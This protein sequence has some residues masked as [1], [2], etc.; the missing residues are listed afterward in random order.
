MPLDKSKPLTSTVTGNRQSHDLCRTHQS[1]HSLIAMRDLD[2]GFGGAGRRW[3]RSAGISEVCDAEIPE[4]RE[5]IRF[6][7]P[8]S[9]HA[10]GVARTSAK[11]LS[12]QD[13]PTLQVR[14]FI[15]TKISASLCIMLLLTT[16]HVCG[17]RTHDLATGSP[18]RYR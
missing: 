5:S 18:M 2:S 11:Y 16:L 10:V 3:A 8:G 14:W 4:I 6:I 17:T 15:H 9:V 12:R 7:L 13:T 1:I